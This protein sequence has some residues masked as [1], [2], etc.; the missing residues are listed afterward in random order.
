MDETLVG[1]DL[2]K[3]NKKKTACNWMRFVSFNCVFGALLFFDVS[4]EIF[5]TLLDRT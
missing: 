4:I 2:C 1:L 3:E 5:P